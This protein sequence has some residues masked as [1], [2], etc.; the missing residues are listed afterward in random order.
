MGQEDFLDV[1]YD[2]Q[3]R[4]KQKQQNA[5]AFREGLYTT[6]YSQNRSELIDLTTV[7][8]NTANGKQQRN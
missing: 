2:T 8:H 1:K 4:F 5:I 3:N 6:D 7:R